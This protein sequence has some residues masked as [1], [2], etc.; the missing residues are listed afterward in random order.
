MLLAYLLITGVYAGVRLPRQPASAWVI[1]A[2]LL[3][4]TLALLVA[5][6]GLGRLGQV[7][8]EIYPLLL[9]PALYP[10]LDILNDFGGVATHDATVRRWERFLFGGEVSRSWWQAH[11]SQIWSAVLHGAYLAYYGVLAAPLVCFLARGRIRDA[12][13]L[14]DWL[15]PTFLICYAVFLSFPVAGPYYEFPR[16]DGRLLANP[17]ARLV[18]ATLERGSAY[19][20]A[21]PSSHVAAALVAT[22]AAFA[23]SRTL[24]ACLAPLAGLLA[25]AVVYCQMHYAVDALAGAVLA[26]IVVGVGTAAER[27]GEVGR[28]STGPTEPPPWAGAEA[29]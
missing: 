13:R 29:R 19:G 12:R 22:A 21:F 2:N 20:A 6:P 5:R 11:P 24:G 28:S 25:I 23:G 26:G 14:V 9:L 18:Y 27:A 16:P 4:A 17:A 15:I 1:A 8:R 10:A 3:A 7:V